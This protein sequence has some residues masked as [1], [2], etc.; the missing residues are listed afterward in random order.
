MEETNEANE[1][2]VAVLE[3]PEV[4]EPVAVAPVKEDKDRE[5]LALTVPEELNN[6]V[7][8]KAK[9]LGLS[10]AA[11]VRNLLAR[12]HSYTIP[13]DFGSKRKYAT[14]DERKAAVAANA[15]KRNEMVAKLLK[16]YRAGKIDIDALIAMGEQDDDDTD[17]N[18]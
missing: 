1:S 5:T 14:D 7:E 4:V 3:N 16:A 2:N 6:I 13:E 18:Q 9:E 15:K 12:E 17:E 10:K 11:Y 8:A